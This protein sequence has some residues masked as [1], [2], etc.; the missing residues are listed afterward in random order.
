VPKVLQELIADDE[1]ERPDVEI[2]IP[3]GKLKLVIGPGGDK[4]KEIQKRSRCRIQTTKSE[5]E[6]SRGFGMGISSVGAAAAAAAA[7]GEKAMTTLQLF[8]SESACEA[9]RELIMEAVEN[10]EYKAKQRERAYEKKKE[11]RAAQ[12]HIYHLRHTRD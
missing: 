11:A 9:A 8:G 2:Q 6:L 1:E 7:A 4:I 12:R 5:A 10:K 3:A